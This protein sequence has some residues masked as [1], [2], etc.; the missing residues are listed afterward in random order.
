M[1]QHIQ[2][3]IVRALVTFVE[4]F[5]PSWAATGYSLGKVALMGAAGS[6]LSIVWNTAVKA[7]VSRQSSS[8]PVSNNPSTVIVSPP[9]NG[10][11]PPV[12]PSEPGK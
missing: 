10:T 12:Q 3:I 6:A 5:I 1:K 11:E 2:D 4:V 7:E 8:A 9:L